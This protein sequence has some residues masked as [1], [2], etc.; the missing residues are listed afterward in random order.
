MI[1][2]PE[3]TGEFDIVTQDPEGYIFYE[4]NSAKAPLTQSM[5]EQEIEQVKAARLDCYRYGFF[6]RSGFEFEPSDDMIFITLDDL[7]S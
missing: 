4:A 7:Y 6:S 5:I 3:P 2:S 1:R